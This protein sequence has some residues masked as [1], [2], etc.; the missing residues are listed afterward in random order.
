MRYSLLKFYYH[1]FIVLNGTGTVYNPLL[2]E[3]PYDSNVEDNDQQFM[4]G[5]EL[6][7]SPVL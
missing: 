2:F 5:R 4:I 3:F 7:F 1:K 6:L